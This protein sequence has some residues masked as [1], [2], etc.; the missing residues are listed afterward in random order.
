MSENHETCFLQNYQ[1]G[2]DAF[3][4]LRNGSLPK[5]IPFAKI[6]FI[7]DGSRSEVSHHKV[8]LF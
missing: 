6:F 2:G 7:R 8:A 5:G 1:T 3:V 4:E